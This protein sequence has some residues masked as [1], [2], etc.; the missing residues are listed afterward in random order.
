MA[1][2]YD[3]LLSRLKIDLGIIHSTAYD[4]RLTSL[5]QV[6]EKEIER[7][8]IK[9]D[10]TDVDDGELLIDYARDL[11]QRRRGENPESAMSKSLRFRLNNRL[12]GKE[13]KSQNPEVNDDG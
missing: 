10:L 7:E 4:S 2:P 9:L 12:F 13:R 11:W 8:G 3:T 6:S 1:E 5:L